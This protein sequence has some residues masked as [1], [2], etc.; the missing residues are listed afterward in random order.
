MWFPELYQW[1]WSCQLCYCTVLYILHSLYVCVWWHMAI[2]KQMV[3]W[4]LKLMN[5][6]MVGINKSCSLYLPH[7][8]N[9]VSVTSIIFYCCHN[10]NFPLQVLNL[11]LFPALLMHNSFCTFP[12]VP[13]RQRKHTAVPD[14]ELCLLTAQLFTSEQS[15]CLGEEIIVMLMLRL[16]LWYGCWFNGLGF[17][18]FFFLFVLI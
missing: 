14:G 8:S 17:E 11:F 18:G 9:P 6:W 10:C 4:V 7:C 13:A 3:L 16:P 12:R 2:N 5:V 1:L 15:A